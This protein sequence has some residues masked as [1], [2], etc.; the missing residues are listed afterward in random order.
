MILF[1]LFH[2]YSTS[3]FHLSPHNLTHLTQDIIEIMTQG[4]TAYFLNMAGDLTYCF[5]HFVAINLE[6]FFSIW[7]AMNQDDLLHKAYLHLVNK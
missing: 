4:K 6:G 5:K 7:S 1:S 3:L 2:I